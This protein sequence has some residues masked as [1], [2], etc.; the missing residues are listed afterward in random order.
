MRKAAL[1]R[2]HKDE[3]RKLMSE[4]RKKENNPFYGKRH[5]LK[6]LNLIKSAAKKQNKTKQNN[7]QNKQSLPCQWANGPLG[8]WATGPTET[9]KQNN[10]AYFKYAELRG[11]NYRIRN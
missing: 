10:S 8:H 6:S 9:N 3:I 11:R 2:K 5:T 4:K 1:G 7:K